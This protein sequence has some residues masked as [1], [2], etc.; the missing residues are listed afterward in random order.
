MIAP[1]AQRRPSWL[2]M[3]VRNE[4]LGLTPLRPR[5]ANGWPFVVGREIN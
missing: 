2:R 1:A 3:Y 5:T 4:N